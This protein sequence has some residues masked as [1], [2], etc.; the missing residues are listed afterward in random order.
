MV[1]RSNKILDIF[2]NPI[3]QKVA[4]LS[5]AEKVHQGYVRVVFHH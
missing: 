3:V 2:V 1:E 4:T 5:I